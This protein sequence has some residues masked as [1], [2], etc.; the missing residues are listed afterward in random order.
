MLKQ[1]IDSYYQN[2]RRFATI[3]GKDIILERIEAVYDE[4]KDVSKQV[5]KGDA[6]IEDKLDSISNRLDQLQ[7]QSQNSPPIATPIQ[8][9]EKISDLRKTLLTRADDAEN[10]YREGYTLLDRYRFKEAIPYLER[11]IANAPLPEFYSALGKAYRFLPDLDRAEHALKEG[12]DQTTELNDQR[13]HADIENE[14]GLVLLDKGDLE[15]ALVRS[16]SALMIDEKLFGRDSRPV[17]TDL[18]NIGNILQEK[19]ETDAAL[20]QLKRALSIQQKASGFLSPDVATILNNLGGILFERGDYDG[21]LGY[22]R[23]ALQIDGTAFGVNSSIVATISANIG[24]ILRARGDLNG[25]LT[26]TLQA[27]A[28]DE[29]I[30]GKSHPETAATYLAAARTLRELGDFGRALD[31]A[32][33]ASGIYDIS[34]P[35]S[36]PNSAVADQ[37][38][39]EIL[40]KKEKARGA[41]ANFDGALKYGN[42]ALE[43]DEKFYGN[44]SPRVA[45]DHGDVCLVLR[46]MGRFDAALEHCLKALT[47]DEQSKDMKDTATVSVSLAAIYSNKGNFDAAIR[48]D[49]RALAIDEKDPGPDSQEVAVDHNDIGQ[50][51][52]RKGKLKEAQYHAELAYRWYSTHFGAYHPD[53]R[54]VKLNLDRIISARLRQP[55]EK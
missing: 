52:E 6:A 1:L 34:Y 50:L 13:G 29:S 53:T 9:T 2:L 46:L 17:A 47:I 40:I 42:N 33:R 24:E 35:S 4:V 19:G 55:R 15:G 10:A 26:A 32:E 21:A 11:A 43:L 27:I 25:A 48:S 38:I 49:E 31:Y 3:S 37:A 36:N 39:C 8:V 44:S 7:A 28:V 14:L 16:K 51:M 23:Q 41:E 20:E 5:K 12:L 18:N 45:V 54:T 22:L 30:W